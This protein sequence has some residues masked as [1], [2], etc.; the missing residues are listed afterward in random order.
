MLA[1]QHQRV[2]VRASAIMAHT[3]E[4]FNERRAKR[5]CSNTRTRKHDRT[6][7]RDQVPFLVNK[8]RPRKQQSVAQD[9]IAPL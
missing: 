1:Q 5:R 4:A 8:S 2:S 7:S 6:T 3:A 9:D